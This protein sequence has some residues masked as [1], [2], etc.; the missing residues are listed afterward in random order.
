MPSR[1]AHSLATTG[2]GPRSRWRP[3]PLP[4]A[5]TSTRPAPDARYRPSPRPA[6]PS[7]LRPERGAD[8]STELTER[9]AGNRDHLGDQRFVVLDR[10]ETDLKGRWRKVDATL[11]HRVEEA[12]EAFAVALHDLA[13]AGR[14]LGAEIDTEHR[15]DRVRTELDLVL[16]CCLRQTI[17][18]QPGTP[19]QGLIKARLLDLF[20][21]CQ[22]TGDRDRVPR[23]GSGLVN[24]SQR[25]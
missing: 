11:Q 16:A 19:G 25:R 21:R 9:L 13:V 4:S 7:G 10:H 17:D 24:G 1:S 2:C 14:H 5:R 15:P 22:A 23:Q 3:A 20:Q 12:V 8:W 18:Q 6:L